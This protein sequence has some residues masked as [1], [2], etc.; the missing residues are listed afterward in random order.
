M[1]LDIRYD[2]IIFNIASISKDNEAWII[3]RRNIPGNGLKSFERITV[4]FFF[5]NH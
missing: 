2:C 5:F 4:F 3:W 1:Y